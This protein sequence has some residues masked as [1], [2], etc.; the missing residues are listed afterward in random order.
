MSNKPRGMPTQ[1]ARLLFKDSPSSTVWRD[2]E[3]LNQLDWQSGSGAKIDITDFKSKAKEN[4][5]GLPDLGNLSIAGNA[6]DKERGP[7][8]LALQLK[9]IRGTDP[10]PVRQCMPVDASQK[11]FVVTEF[12]CTI[13]KFDTSAKVDDK[14]GY[15][16]TLPI[17]DVVNVYDGVELDDLD[18]D[19]LTDGLL[20]E[21]AEEEEEGEE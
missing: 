4:L 2:V 12:I 18:S 9:N 16:A 8:Q 10:F 3:S 21:E 14:Q 11:K 5:K 1:G 17:N 7:N 20:D 13:D 6:L 19:A 15:T